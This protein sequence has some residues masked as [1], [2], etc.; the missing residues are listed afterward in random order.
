MSI[1]VKVGT[2]PDNWGVWFPS[3]PKQIPWERFLDEVEESGYRWIE[4]GPPG[5]LPPDPVLLAPELKKRGLVATTGFVMHHL[6]DPA[7][8]PTIE[9]ELNSVGSV[10]QKLGAPFLLLID[11]TYTDLSGG[12]LVRPRELNDDDWKRLIDATHR[13]A[14]IA[15]D[16]YGLRVVFHPHTDTHVEFEHQIERF[17]KDTDPELVSLCLDTGHHAYRGGNPVEFMRR[18]HSR[19]PYLHLKSVDSEIRR[20]VEDEK[21]PFAKAVGIGVFC[22]PSKGAVDFHAFRDVLNQVNYEGWAIVEQDMYPAPFEKPMPI[23][24]R[25]RAYL[26]EIGIG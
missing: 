2:A 6:E 22:E 16:R 15:R 5:Y 19:I 12:K 4:L 24:K 10:L 7:L 25:T 11:D 23:A 20:R 21:I 13:V 14:K 3:D 17:L 9:A 1:D 18:H 8:W 26:R